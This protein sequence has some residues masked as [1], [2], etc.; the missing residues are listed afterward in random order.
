[1]WLEQFFHGKYLRGRRG[2][3]NILRYPAVLL[4]QVT[5]YFMSDGHLYLFVVEKV[6]LSF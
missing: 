5:D 3:A 4:A 6:A 1:M 2:I